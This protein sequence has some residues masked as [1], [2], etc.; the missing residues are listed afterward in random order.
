MSFLGFV[1]QLNHLSTRL[2][3]LAA[4]LRALLKKE[5]KW[6]WGHQ[7]VEAFAAIKRELSGPPCLAPYVL[8][9]E[10]KVVTDASRQGLGAAL[11]QL[12]VDGRWRMISAASRSLTPTEQRYAAI[13]LEAL[14]VKWALERFRYYVLGR[15]VV[16]QTCLL[17]TSPSPRDS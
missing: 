12:Q 16:V 6:Y 10:T 5:E 1:N 4:P 8:S 14:A 17:Y 3:D 15:T 9:R 11:L 13:E 7:Q 2:S